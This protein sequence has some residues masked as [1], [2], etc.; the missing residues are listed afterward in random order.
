[1]FERSIRVVTLETRKPGFYKNTVLL[2]TMFAILCFF[3]L[4]I[5]A[6]FGLIPNVSILYIQILP[7]LIIFFNCFILTQEF[8]NH[9]DKQIFSGIYNRTEIL[10]AKLSSI[11]LQSLILSLI[12]IVLIVL[13]PD[14]ASALE[15]TNAVNIILVFGGYGFIAG[16]FILMLSVITLNGFITGI[17][18]YLLFFDLFQQLLRQASASISNPFFS[19]LIN[20]SPFLVANTGLLSLQYDPGQLASLIVWGCIFL[21]I[22]RT[23]LIRKNI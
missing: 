11:C 17:V 12:F 3:A 6:H 21:L 20:N 7:Y 2:L 23:L 22:T 10:V 8:S 15:A 19:M 9:T 4:K 1:M 14:N 5:C 13:F 18:T 16:T